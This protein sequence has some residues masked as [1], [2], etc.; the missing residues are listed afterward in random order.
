M[1]K[2]HVEVIQCLSIG[3]RRK[4]DVEHVILSSYVFG[5]VTECVRWLLSPRSSLLN[6]YCRTR[7]EVKR[8]E[9]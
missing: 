1:N 2:D 7:A 4:K 8:G 3:E 5:N 6:N 9:K